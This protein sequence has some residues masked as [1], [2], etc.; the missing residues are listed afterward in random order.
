M[1]KWLKA[2]VIGVSMVAAQASAVELQLT[3]DGQEPVIMVC[4]VSCQNPNGFPD[5]PKEYPCAALPAIED[6][7]KMIVFATTKVSLEK[8]VKDLR[9]LTEQE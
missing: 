8:V 5:V 4:Y 9:M 2:G 1:K 3:M 7:C 6:N